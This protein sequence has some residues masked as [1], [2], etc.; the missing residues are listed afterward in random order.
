[1]NIYVYEYHVHKRLGKVSFI[2]I[3]NNNVNKYTEPVLLRKI[4]WKFN[5]YRV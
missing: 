3:S 2:Y 5:A 1:M 4:T